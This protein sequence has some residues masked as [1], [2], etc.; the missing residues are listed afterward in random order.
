MGSIF[1]DNKAANDSIQKTTGLGS[2]LASTLGNGI[3]TA[4]KVG[5][6]L[7]SMAIA[8][9]TSLLAIANKSAATTDRIDKMSQK[10]NLSRE[11]FKS[12]NMYYP[13]MELK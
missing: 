9:G 10:L 1:V 3:K 13:K 7:T 2:K 6:A 12:G 5:T 4:A 8:G 11:G